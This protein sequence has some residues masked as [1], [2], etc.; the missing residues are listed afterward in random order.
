MATTNVLISVYRGQDV[1]QPCKLTSTTQ[2]I[3]SWTI[4]FTASQLIDFRFPPSSGVP[5]VVIFTSTAS[6]TSG[7]TQQFQFT[8]SAAQLTIPATDY[9]FDIRRTDSGNNTVLGTGTL[10]VTATS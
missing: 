6:I 2:D 8:F 10:R 3:S 4:V 5:T 7:P 9:S 1:L